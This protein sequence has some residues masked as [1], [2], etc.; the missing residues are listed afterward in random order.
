[1]AKFSPSEEE[2]L[3]HIISTLPI[4][5]DGEHPDYKDAS[6]K[7]KAWDKIAE[8]MKKEKIDCKKRWRNIKDTWSRK[9]KKPGTGTAASSS[10]KWH[11]FPFLSFLDNVKFERAS[12]STMTSTEPDE[13]STD[14]FEGTEDS[15]AVSSNNQPSTTP[16]SQHPL[17][18]GSNSETPSYGNTNKKARF[19]SKYEAFEKRAEARMELLKKVVET[20]EDDVDLFLK[21]IGL[22]IKKLPL[23]MISDAKLQILKVVSKLEKRPRDWPHEAPDGTQPS[24]SHPIPQEESPQ[25]FYLSDSE[26]GTFI[27]L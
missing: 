27:N 8:V 12:Q 16:Q 13:F 18:G 6:K 3:L 22:T 1:M 11:L 9:K 25:N 2:T 15:Q 19:S 23:H 17:E 14:H 24:V 7:K 20:E 5:F 10:K 4:I 21:S 26:H